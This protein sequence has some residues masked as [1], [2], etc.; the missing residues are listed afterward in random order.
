MI[1]T[2]ESDHQCAIS[3]AAFA[4]GM[5]NGGWQ[6]LPPEDQASSSRDRSIHRLIR[7]LAAP[8]SAVAG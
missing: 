7:Q 2:S 3:G 8:A 5:S 4:G 6:G 1:R